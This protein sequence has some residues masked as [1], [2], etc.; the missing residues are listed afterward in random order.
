MKQP[1]KLKPIANR[2]YY[3]NRKLKDFDIDFNIKTGEIKLP[4]KRFIDIPIGLRFYIGECIKL[5]Y[6]VQYEIEAAFRTLPK[7][8]NKEKSKEELVPP[9]KKRQ[10]I[11]KDP[12]IS[13][14]NQ[15]EL[16]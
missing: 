9:V 15:T 13:I 2:R 12:V 7:A 10:Y 16:F 11:K 6:N 8:K 14:P 1:N 5:Q 4:Y 3:M